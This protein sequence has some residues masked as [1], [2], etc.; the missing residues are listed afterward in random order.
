MRYK[1]ATASFIFL[2]TLLEMPVA[3]SQW[4]YTNGP[5]IDGYPGV[6]HFLTA[7][8]SS[9][10]AGSEDPL[11]F[12]GTAITTD[13]GATWEES[14]NGIQFLPSYAMI[15]SNGNLFAGTENGLYRSTNNGSS[16]IQSG[17]PNIVW[18]FAASGTNVFAGTVGQG[19]YLST[20]SGASWV[21]VNSGFD[22]TAA[23]DALAISS[24]T[25]V[26]GGED[27][28]GIFV[29]T[30]NGA[31]WASANAGLTNLD[32]LS[33]TPVGTN[34]YAGTGGGIFLSANNGTSWTNIYSGSLIASIVTNGNYLFASGDGGVFLSTNNGT[35]W[36]AVDSE[37]PDYGIP[38]GALAVDGAYLFAGT[39][40]GVWRRPLSDFNQSG[41][42]SSS[43]PTSNGMT[44]FPAIADKSENVIASPSAKASEFEIVNSLGVVVDQ[45]RVTSG[46]G[47]FTITTSGLPEGFYI[48]RLI[49]ETGTETAKFIVRH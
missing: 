47:E 32:V 34:L 3:R 14:D 23:V 49:S 24:T 18:S 25:L 7:I 46:S 39:G 12:A 11:N 27:G 36:S 10:F 37:L 33:L 13:Y 9:L 2:L 41:V 48:C 26:A 44:L 42:A 28:S 6:T 29:S 31:S 17:L 43:T 1:I 4:V 30:N 21:P 16:W 5:N 38:V 35:S 15:V 40:R 8:D 20:D 22:T 19:V 45:Q